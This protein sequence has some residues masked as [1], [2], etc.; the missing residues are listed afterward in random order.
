MP[1]WMRPVGKPGHEKEDIIEMD[2]KGAGRVDR[3]KQAQDTA[4]L[5]AVV[6]TAQT[7]GFP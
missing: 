7:I 5:L 6:N 2:R 1:K 4:H 3:N